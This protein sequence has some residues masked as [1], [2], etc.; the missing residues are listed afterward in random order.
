MNQ[1][2]RVVLFLSVVFYSIFFYS[3]SLLN[4]EQKTSKIC[5][6]LP[7]ISSTRTI[8]YNADGK[9][10]FDDDER[11]KREMIDVYEIS[12]VSSTGKVITQ[13]VAKT[14][15]SI[16]ISEIP[17]GKCSIE[18]RA[19]AIDVTQGNKK[20]IV[21]KN[22][23]PIEVEIVESEVATVTINP[24]FVKYSIGD[25]EDFVLLGTD[26]TRTI[27]EDY[28][29]IVPIGEIFSFVSAT[30]EEIDNVRITKDGK[31]IPLKPGLDS[32]K[33]IRIIDG[34]AIG[35]V[36]INV[37]PSVTVNF[38]VD[39]EPFGS[40]SFAI[41]PNTIEGFLSTFT[42]D[43][44]IEDSALFKGWY[45]T[46][47]YS[48]GTDVPKDENTGYLDLTEKFNSL[49]GSNKLSTQ[50]NIYAKG[51]FITNGTEFVTALSN[52]YPSYNGDYILDGS[53][54]GGKLKIGSEAVVEKDT[55]LKFR[56]DVQLK[57]E[58]NYHGIMMTVDSG[59]KLTIMPDDGYENN[60]MQFNGETVSNEGYASAKMVELKSDVGSKF[61]N[62]IFENNKINEPNNHPSA[63]M[64]N[65]TGQNE[66]INCSIINNSI[67]NDY[68]RAPGIK[69]ES[70]ANVVINGMEFSGNTC[71]DYPYGLDIWLENSSASLTLKGIIKNSNGVTLHYKNSTTNSKPIVA[72]D[73]DAKNSS[74][75]KLTY[76]ENNESCS[77]PEDGKQ[78]FDFGSNGNSLCGLFGFYILVENEPKW[79]NQ[80]NDSSITFEGKFKS[81]D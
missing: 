72:K 42:T 2:T 7:Q 20:F 73:L 12:I 30:G 35:T 38:I 21:A 69:I 26:N 27:L 81:N 46:S 64:I 58:N 23:V 65:G 13:S 80:L 61:Q 52:A 62:V 55:I 53:K 56:T 50:I 6:K 57:R 63:I 51:R 28:N 66:F 31:I 5:I 54:F 32:I 34:E 9:I 33:L 36:N 44:P 45:W 49:N 14:E 24:R 17:V 43:L 60:Y 77:V 67:S 1:R 3:C 29:N 74:Q 11:L 37:E 75:F 76:G 22:A 19:Y 10:D 16:T 78:L 47:E 18:F 15:A 4:L 8:G 48:S 71:N 59:A 25:T 79:I 41:G 39:G 68:S 40:K 70:G